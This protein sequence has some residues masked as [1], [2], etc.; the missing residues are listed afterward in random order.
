MNC[1]LVVLVAQRSPPL[2]KLNV[3]GSIAG[4]NIRF[5]PFFIFEFCKFRLSSKSVSGVNN[6]EITIK[7]AVQKLLESMNKCRLKK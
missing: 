6:Q 3:T 7:C 4:G 5:A 2:K 1:Q